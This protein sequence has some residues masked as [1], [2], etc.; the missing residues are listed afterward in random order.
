[1][2]WWLEPWTSTLSGISLGFCLLDFLVLG[3]TVRVRRYIG[4]VKE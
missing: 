1:V 4:L 2:A 3:I